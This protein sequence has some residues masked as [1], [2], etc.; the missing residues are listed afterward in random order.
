[1]SYLKTISMYFL[2][3]SLF[4]LS[5]VFWQINYFIIWRVWLFWTCA[6]SRGSFICVGIILSSLSCINISTSSSQ[7]VPQ[8]S[9]IH[10]PQFM[11]LGI[12]YLFTNK[13]EKMNS[14]P[15]ESL[16]WSAETCSSRP[17][18]GLK[19]DIS[20]VLKEASNGADFAQFLLNQTNRIT[21]LIKFV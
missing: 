5:I 18:A 8:F 11:T 1:M 17:V 20:E 7:V 21:I 9:H 15:A 3:S 14:D 12:T 13:T 19:T 16:N 4:S 10:M 6:I 2:H